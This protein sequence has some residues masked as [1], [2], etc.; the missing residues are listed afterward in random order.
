MCRGDGRHQRGD[1]LSESGERGDALIV[2]RRSGRR[3]ETFAHE[4]LCCVILRI[5]ANLNAG[6]AFSRF[7]Y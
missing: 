7:H 5:I 3:G 4:N 6:T 2:F 1:A